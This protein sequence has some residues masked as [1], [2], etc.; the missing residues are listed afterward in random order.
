MIAISVGIL[1]EVFLVFGVCLEKLGVIN[2]AGVDGWLEIRRY[3]VLV[4]G[5]LQFLHHLVGNLGLCRVGTENDAGVL[6]T[7]IVALT[8]LGGRVVK[9]EKELDQFFEQFRSRIG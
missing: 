8:V 6:R 1:E 7:D 2:D 9:H 3:F 4:H 5:F